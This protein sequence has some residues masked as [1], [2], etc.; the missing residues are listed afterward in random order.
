[1]LPHS[2]KGSWQRSFLGDVYLLSAFLPKSKNICVRLIS[3][4]KIA[5]VSVSHCWI[6][7]WKWINFIQECSLTTNQ[8]NSTVKNREMSCSVLPTTSSQT[9]V[10]LCLWYNDSFLQQ[11]S[12]LF[13]TKLST[14]PRAAHGVPQDSV[15]GLHKLILLVTM[16]WIFIAV[17]M[18]LMYTYL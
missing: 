6:D 15:L 16:A 14:Y 1:M 11:G 9:S 3:D 5:C 13:R 7:G 8:L 18:T 4:C 12:G 10:H 17:Q 2:K